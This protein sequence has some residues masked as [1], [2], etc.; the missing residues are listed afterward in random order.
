M[1]LLGVLVEEYDRRHALPPSDSTPGQRL[2]YLLEI[3]GRAPADLLSVFGQRSHIH[4]ALKGKR[5]ISAAQARK[6]AAMFCVSPGLF[7]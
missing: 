6:L 2:N 1:K 3:S 4:E 7:I 5:P